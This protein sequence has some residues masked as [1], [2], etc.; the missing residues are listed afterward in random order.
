MEESIVRNVD[1]N[2]DGV[3]NNSIRPENL[4]EYVGQKDVVDNIKV[5]LKL[6]KLEVKP[7][8][9]FYYMALQ[10]LEKRLLLILL[11]MRWEPIL[12]PLVVLA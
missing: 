7:L 11:L 1:V 10:V 12:K 3:D 9:M 5:L 4:L 6:R 8:I 2:D